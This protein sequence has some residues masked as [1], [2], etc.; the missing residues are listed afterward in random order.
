MDR[1]DNFSSVSRIKLAATLQIIKSQTDQQA[2]IQTKTER[3]GRQTNIEMTWLRVEAN[4]LCAL[5]IV[6]VISTLLARPS[7]TSIDLLIN[8]VSYGHTDTSI[9][10]L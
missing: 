8:S 10:H 2:E 4:V 9:R 1:L 3:Q 5:C 7:I 6:I